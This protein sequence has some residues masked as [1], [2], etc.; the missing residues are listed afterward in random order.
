MKVNIYIYRVANLKAIAPL[1]TEHILKTNC[2]FE[3]A[4]PHYNNL[5]ASWEKTHSVLGG[6]VK[7]RSPIRNIFSQ[8]NVVLLSQNCNLFCI[9]IHNL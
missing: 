2:N 5:T 6:V 4:I 1:A 7:R 3:M 8:Y 9:A